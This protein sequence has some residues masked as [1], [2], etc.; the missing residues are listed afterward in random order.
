[1]P[2][3]FYCSKCTSQHP[4]PVGKRCRLAGE[5]LVGDVEVV[6]SPSPST[7]DQSTAFDQLLIRLQQ[8]GTK[9]T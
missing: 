1:M 5:S 7:S 3:V 2:K 8:I 9:W 4:S 6:V